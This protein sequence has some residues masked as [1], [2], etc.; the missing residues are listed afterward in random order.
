M[1]KRFFISLSIAVCLCM[2]SCEKDVAVNQEKVAVEE[3]KNN[4]SRPLEFS[5]KESLLDAIKAFDPDAPAT[6]SLVTGFVSYYDSVMQEED[7][8]ERPNA[9]FSEAFGSILNPEG[10]VIYGDTFLKV[11]LQ[12]LF[13][14]PVDVIENIRLL[15]K[16]ENIDI[17]SFEKVLVGDNE[18][19]RFIDNPSIYLS[20]TFGMFSDSPSSDSETLMTRTDIATYSDPSVGVFWGEVKTKKGGEMDNDYIWPRGSAQ[21]TNFTSKVVNDTKIY[22]QHFAGLYDESGVKTK[23]MKKKGIFWNKFTANVTS[24]VIGV[25]ISE[26][27]Y[28]LKTIPPYGWYDV[29]KTHYKGETFMIATKVVASYAGLPVNS[30]AVDNECNDALIWAKQNGVNISDVEGVRYVVTSMPDISPVRLKDKIVQKNAAKNTLIFNLLTSGGTFYI[31]EGKVHGFKNKG[32]S[33]YSVDLIVYYGFSEYNGEKR[34]FKLICARNA[35]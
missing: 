22:K 30:K 16:S 11:G 1:K 32:T 3:I 25:L 17:N 18:E 29:S 24:A 7:Y 34:G 8:D 10:E 31:D 4:L 19:Y 14:G 27:G 13:Y 21:K 12:G 9:I 28:E 33:P 2:A 23:T 6:R 15:A 35:N 20:D 26:Q 5:S